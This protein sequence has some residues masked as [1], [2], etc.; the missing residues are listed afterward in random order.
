MTEN[1]NRLEWERYV[2][3]ELPPDRARALADRLADDPRLG[4]EIEEIKRSNR[5]DLDRYPA[6]RVVP[7]I[8][9]RLLRKT[10][11]PGESGR[12]SRSSAR[13]RLFFLVPAL[14]AAALLTVI[15]L[16]DRIRDDGLVKGSAGLDLSRTR[17]LVYRMRNLIV[18]ELTEGAVS[19]AGDILQLAYVSTEKFGVILSI[20][21]AGT[22]SLQYPD[23][24]GAS[25]PLEPKRKTILP[26]AVELDRA[27]GFERMFFVTSDMPFNTQTVR[28][29][30]EAL[31]RNP[32]RAERD[33]LALPPQLHQTSF[34]VRKEAGNAPR[35]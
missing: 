27:P 26:L 5:E 16:P 17:L 29:A 28:A 7:Q 10:G 1:I 4:R 25:A 6:A 21:G 33:S 32:A 23:R 11:D 8:C 35:D 15:L 12:D 22:V 3:G 2:L 14:A 18:E 9:E 24:E 30:A 19:R 34:L 31:A 13:K 20:D